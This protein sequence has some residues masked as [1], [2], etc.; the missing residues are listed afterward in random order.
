MLG[1][2]A[3]S[4]A[5]TLSVIVTGTNSG[6]LLSPTLASVWTQKWVQPEI[7]VVDGGSTDGTREWLERQRGKLTAILVEPG[8]SPYAAINRGL[9]AATGEWV[10]VLA[11]G[12]RLVGDMVLSE[13]SNWIKK[14]EAGIVAGEV[15][16]DDGLIFRLRSRVN[17]LA[18]NFLP[19][20]AAFYRR[21]LFAENGSFDPALGAMADYDFNVRLWKN[22]VRFKPIPL[23]ITAS[24]LRPA[25]HSGRWQATREGI[26]VRHRYFSPL[27]CLPWD[28]VSVLRY[29]VRKIPSPFTRPR[30]GLA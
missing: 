29:A 19:R 13:V 26:T 8:G 5:P 27:A 3:M 7:T 10:L 20:A 21:T 22:R 17:P 4:A 2:N 14:T 9:A 15:A 30:S 18:G 12:E 1:A 28:A 6:P 16:Y 23:R 11:A 24:S 25:S